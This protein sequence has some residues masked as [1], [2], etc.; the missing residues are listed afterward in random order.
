MKAT[1]I[2]RRID[3]LGRVVIPKE[4]RRNYNIEEGDALEIF[5]TKEGIVLA[6]YE[7]PAESSAK[8]AR[9]WLTKNR[10]QMT[11][12]GA[13]FSIIG[14]TTVCEVIRNN[15]RHTGEA[16]CK[17]SDEFDPS[18]GMVV[19]YCRATGQRVPEDILDN[20]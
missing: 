9:Q 6:P 5:T 15:M 14:T 10:Q 3:D 18:V 17:P 8:A 4:I 2:I 12:M 19:A 11:A 13:K 20:D 16:K 7:K 1:G